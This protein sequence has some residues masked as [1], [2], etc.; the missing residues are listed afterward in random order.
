MTIADI[1][2]ELGRASGAQLSTDDADLLNL[3]L[4][5][6]S[7][8]ITLP[9]DIYGRAYVELDVTPASS[10][11]SYQYLPSASSGTCSPTSFL[12][13]TIVSIQ[14][15][16]AQWGFGQIEPFQI[17]LDGNLSSSYLPRM[18]D[19]ESGNTY[20]FNRRVYDSEDDT[21]AFFMGDQSP[22]STGT[23]PWSNTTTKTVKL[24]VEP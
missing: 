21:T 12:G 20:N 11:V 8:P 14:S 18:I 22:T 16:G 15:R 4:K 5:E 19:T 1:N 2:T 24:I 7:D 13:V 23:S 17:T 3:G 6:S 9:D 10:G